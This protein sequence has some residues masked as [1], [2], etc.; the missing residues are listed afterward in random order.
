MNSLLRLSPHLFAWRKL[1]QHLQTLRFSTYLGPKLCCVKSALHKG[2]VSE[3]DMMHN[4]AKRVCFMAL[5]TVPTISILNVYLARSYSHALLFTHTHTHTH[6]GCIPQGK[7]SIS[8]T[9]FSG[10][11]TS[12][13]HP[14]IHLFF[15]SLRD[16]YFSLSFFPFP[17][18][19]AVPPSESALAHL[20]RCSM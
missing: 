19:R 9:G 16:I 18:L 4:K 1:I 20:L 15:F 8:F 13:L 3:F 6:L 11:V 2:D 10:K 17:P 7:S 5:V 14:Q 12:S